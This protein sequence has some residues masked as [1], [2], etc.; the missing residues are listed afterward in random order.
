[1]VGCAVT[2]LPWA[3]QQAG[4]V[5]GFILCFTSFIISWYT[6]KLI[7]DM[8]GTDP[9]YS[10]TLRKFYGKCYGLVK[11]ILFYV[12]FESYDYLF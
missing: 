11:I 7:I 9:D 5:L 3:F 2:I 8:S 10:I 6:C 4:M 1:M 12:V